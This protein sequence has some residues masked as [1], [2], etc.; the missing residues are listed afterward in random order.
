LRRR[1]SRAARRPTPGIGQPDGRFGFQDQVT[2]IG[3]EAAWFHNFILLP[4]ITEI[5]LFRLVLL[6]GCVRYRRS[7]NPVPSRTVAQHLIEVLW[8]LVRC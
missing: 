4:L 6:L 5:S 8:T 7:A 3:E 2:P 1:P